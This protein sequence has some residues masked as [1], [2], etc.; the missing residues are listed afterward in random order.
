MDVS[1]IIVNYNTSEVTKNCIDSIYE[2]TK[3][4]NF[5]II[6]V[7]NNSKDNSKIIFSK[8]SRI[9]YLYQNSNLGFGKA[10]NIGFKHAKGK[11]LFLLNSDTLLRSNAVKE[12][13]DYME[14][15]SNNIACIGTILVDVEGHAMTSFGRFPNFWTGITWFTILGPVLQKLRLIK[16]NHHQNEEKYVDYVS[17]ADIF[18]KRSIAMELGLFDPE[19]FMYFEETEM[20]YRFTQK[21][22][23]NLIYDKPHIIHLEGY[24]M[25]K[26]YKKTLS[27]L[28]LPL[29]GYFIYLKKTRG[30]FIYC[31]FRFLYALISP[32]W[33]I[34][35]RYSFKDKLAYMKEA[36]R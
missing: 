25:N 33:L 18:L 2:Y 19:F 4:V 31:L 6:L 36:Y 12:F 15:C 29:K 9:K 5:E 26:V 30:I 7:D 14:K 28:I 34:D 1:I 10:N 22:Y 17:G 32:F 24:S 27:K 11:Y 13:Y 35:P 23:K 8:D 3:E 21:G 16:E 20:Q